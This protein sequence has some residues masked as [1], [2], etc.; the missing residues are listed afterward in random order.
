MTDAETIAQLRRDVDMLT[1]LMIGLV[2]AAEMRT[3]VAV[4]NHE[5]AAEHTVMGLITLS[6]LAMQQ[7]QVL[8]LENQDR[9]GLTGATKAGYESFLARL[10][11]A[12]GEYALPVMSET[13]LAA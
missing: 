4:Q 12:I 8:R 11:D 1:G 13:A 5:D 7:S 10:N 2:S 9:T 6:E 3:R